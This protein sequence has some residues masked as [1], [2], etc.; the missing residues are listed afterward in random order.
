M[1][2]NISI[3]N[4]KRIVCCP[5]WKSLSFGGTIPVGDII[6]SDCAKCGDYKKLH[7]IFTLECGFKKETTL[8][9]IQK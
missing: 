6:L 5:R 8:N 1:L 4:N 7:S 2:L 3:R 9:G